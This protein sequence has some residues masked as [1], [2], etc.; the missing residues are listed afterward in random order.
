M[1]QPATKSKAS[2]T[3]TMLRRGKK[4][5]VL[6]FFVFLARQEFLKKF[7]RTGAKDFISFPLEQAVIHGS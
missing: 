4:R 7:K 3:K 2:R 6:W 1:L 5:P